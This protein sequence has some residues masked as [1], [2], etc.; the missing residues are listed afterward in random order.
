ML[1]HQIEANQSTIIRSQKLI[2]RPDTVLAE[3]GDSV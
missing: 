1:L 2:A 3:P